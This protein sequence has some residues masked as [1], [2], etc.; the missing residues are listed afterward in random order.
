MDQA[1]R[2]LP[3]SEDSQVA[4][5][6]VLLWVY[7]FSL[8]SIIPLIPHYSMPYQFNISLRKYIHGS[9]S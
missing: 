3:L 5:E 9:G 8:V 7:Q 1:V 2:H 6:W 4:L